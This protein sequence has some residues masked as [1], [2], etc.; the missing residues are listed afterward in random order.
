[1]SRQR[2]QIT[3][4]GM[5]RATFWTGVF[6]AAGSSYLRERLSW[7]STFIALLCVILGMTS[8]LMAVAVLRGRRTGWRAVLV[9]GVV[10]ILLV[11]IT[12]NR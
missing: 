9:A 6:A 11:A 10:S 8:G 1:M 12:T 3:L 4:Q 2:V 7:N 5:F